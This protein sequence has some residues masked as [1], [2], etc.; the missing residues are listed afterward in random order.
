MERQIQLQYQLQERQ[1]AM[2]I[3]KD[4]DICLWLT[5]FHITSTVGLFT[6]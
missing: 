4:R 5:A 2:K 1:A 3:A 6:G